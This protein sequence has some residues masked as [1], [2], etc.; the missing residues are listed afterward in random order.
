[1]ERESN[2]T[3]LQARLRKEI[4]DGSPRPRP[5]GSRAQV[6]PD[7]VY[8]PANARLTACS[9]LSSFQI[10]FREAHKNLPHAFTGGTH[11]GLIILLVDNFT[12]AYIRYFNLMDIDVYIMD[13]QHCITFWCKYAILNE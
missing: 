1:M 10:L 9:V 13:V 11:H 2:L 8:V 6:P 3:V 5:V 7:H 4:R 12:V